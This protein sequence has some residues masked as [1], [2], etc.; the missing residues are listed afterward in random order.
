MES[1]TTAFLQHPP[2]QDDPGMTYAFSFDGLG[3]PCHLVDN[4]L[5]PRLGVGRNS[6]AI[7]HPP[8]LTPVDAPR[9]VAR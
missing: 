1:L 4:P 6:P 2:V 3:R 7:P 9:T 8:D 5:A